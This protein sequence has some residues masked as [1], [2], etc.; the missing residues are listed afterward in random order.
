M[1]IEQ[2]KKQFDDLKSGTT[3]AFIMRMDQNKRLSLDRIA[4]LSRNPNPVVIEPKELK[5]SDILVEVTKTRNEETG[6]DEYET[7]YST[8]NE[9]V[10]KLKQPYPFH[11]LLSHFFYLIFFQN[12]SL[13]L[14]S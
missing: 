11:F 3:L 1:P 10:F 6:H 14:L 9:Q 2:A 13:S 12:I 8:H 4:L 7:F 5:F